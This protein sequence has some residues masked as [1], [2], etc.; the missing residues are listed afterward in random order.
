MTFA[1]IIT[2]S[3]LRMLSRD[4]GPFVI[5][6]FM[7]LVLMAFIESAFGAAQAVPG[8]AVMFSF[9]L[10]TTVGIGIFREYAWGTW[11]RLRVSQAGTAEILAG[12]STAPF[13]VSLAQFAVLFAA[14]RLIFGLQ[15]EGTIF[16]L[17]LVAGSLAICLVAIGMASVAVSRSFQQLTT[18]NNLGTLV[19]AGIGGAITPYESLPTWAQ[20]LAPA[21][22]CYWAMRGFK[23][24]IRPGGGLS[25]VAPSIGVLLGF[26]IGA[27]V[28]A[29]WRMRLDEAKTGWM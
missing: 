3:E 10:V 4:P 24:A 28:L 14:G 16:G 8:M 23:S 29:L 2:R 27:A 15:I 19:L 1:L 18:F 22:P 12:K 20:H 13:L 25:D 11:D 9:F 7:P 17:A 21:S 6:V 5:L 26:A